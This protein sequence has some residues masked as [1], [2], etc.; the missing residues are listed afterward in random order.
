[1]YFV[2]RHEET[3][4]V[5][6]KLVLFFMLIFVV[7]RVTPIVKVLGWR[8]C[9]H[10]EG[11]F[12]T[13]L[14]LWEELWDA[15]LFLHVFELVC[16]VRSLTSC[17]VFAKICDVWGSLTSTFNHV[18]H[19][20]A[21]VIKLAL[22][23]FT[24][25]ILNCTVLKVAWHWSLSLGSFWSFYGASLEC[26]VSVSEW[27]HHEVEEVVHHFAVGATAWFACFLFVRMTMWQW[28]RH[29]WKEWHLEWWSW[30]NSGSILLVTA[31]T[32]RSC[33]RFCF[34]HFLL[35]LRFSFDLIF[36]NLIFVY[37][38]VI[39]D[40]IEIVSTVSILWCIVTIASIPGVPHRRDIRTVVGLP[41]N[42]LWCREFLDWFFLYLQFS[43]WWVRVS[44]LLIITW[45]AWLKCRARTDDVGL[46]VVLGLLSWEEC[47]PL[48]LNQFQLVF[49][50]LVTLLLLI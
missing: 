20:L 44:V 46:L 28:A 27:L 12:L 8:Q 18:L 15:V 35:S 40:I 32:L 41:N 43:L 38:N 23:N 36:I 14:E 29:E 39:G 5:I 9:S 7:A 11:W 19:S 13:W 3:L 16:S 24:V 10:W 33:L 4:L 25:S 21:A 45:Y 22:Q 34:D 6:D 48:M 37:N 26:F 49:G 50:F 17:F 2:T 47:G 30:W 42:F 1:M 31:V